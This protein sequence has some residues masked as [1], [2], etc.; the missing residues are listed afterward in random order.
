MSQNKITII[1][2]AVDRTTG[3]VKRLNER[4]G[5]IAAP[6]RAL[7]KSFD[8]LFEEGRAKR[9]GKALE[10]VGKRWD[11]TTRSVGAIAAVGAVATG[12]LGG[13]YLALKRVTDG[14]ENAL[15]ASQRFGTTITDWQKLSYAA[16]MADVSSDD[17]GNSLG[18]LNKRAIAAATG[19]MESAQWFRRA[20]IQIKDHNGK[21]KT[22]TQLLSELAD[23]FQKMP[24]G[25]KKLALANGLL[26]D[27]EGKMIPFLNGGSAAMREAGK[28]AEALGLTNEQLARDS[29]T[30]ND[31]S[32]KVSFAMRGVGNAIAA[33]VLP[34]MNELLPKLGKW[35]SANRG[36]V[37]TK[38]QAF[39]KA[40]SENLPQLIDGLT[41][42]VKVVGTV[43]SAVNTVVQWF[44][45]WGTVVGAVA[46]IMAGKM[47]WSVVMLTK[48]IATLGAVTAL[49]PFG[50]FISAA[51]A[52]GGVGYLVWKHWAPIKQFFV[53]LWDGIVGAFQKGYDWIK[54]IVLKVDEL[55]PDW[56]KKFTLPGAAIAA[57][58][59][60]MREPATPLA[61]GG[62]IVSPLTPIAAQRAGVA[63]AKANIAIEVN[64][65]RTKVTEIKS[66]TPGVTFDVDSGYMTGW[67]Y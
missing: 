28:E 31:E 50:I 34:A 19:N 48:A 33:A 58:A 14:N 51:A 44:G 36:V 29:A 41:A 53:D 64:D 61:G 6:G 15:K 8:A 45:G 32:K 23:L 21:V 9:F 52:L 10:E 4:L 39:V 59:N 17:L 1:V 55:V 7:G 47:I 37:A 3:V 67:A 49:T 60:A 62:A 30:F 57:A 56:M 40:F 24:D 25:P 13:M 16:E 5:R 20:G 38:A 43:A 63:G 42:V 27:S 54:K 66:N 35:I 2:Q 18:S 46:G 22:S 65:K 12:A 11:K 26:K